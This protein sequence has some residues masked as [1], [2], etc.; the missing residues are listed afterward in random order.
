MLFRT[1]VRMP[2]VAVVVQVL[3][4]MP[5][6]LRHREDQQRN[7]EQAGNKPQLLH[8]NKFTAKLRCGRGV[9]FCSDPSL[10]VPAHFWF[11]VPHDPHQQHNRR[12]RKD[13]F[14]LPVERGDLRHGIGF[15]Q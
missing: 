6:L 7:K 11:F 12:Y 13:R 10:I 2:A 8:H 9:T 5:R 15:N 1:K 4:F 3:Q 14:S